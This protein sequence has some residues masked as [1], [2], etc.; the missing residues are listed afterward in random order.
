MGNS[1][2]SEIRKRAQVYY[3]LKQELID[4]ASQVNTSTTALSPTIRGVY[5]DDLD[6]VS[7]ELLDFLDDRLA[8]VQRAIHAVT[9]YRTVV[10]SGYGAD[11][12]TVR[13]ENAKEFLNN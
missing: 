12:L 6:W 1:E 7:T 2:L 9:A 13:E 3:A 11:Y 4:A 8:R 5:E 10:Q